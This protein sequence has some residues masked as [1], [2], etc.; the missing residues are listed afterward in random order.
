MKKIL[1][2]ISVVFWTFSITAP[3]GA[4]GLNM[5][6]GLWQITS[7]VSMPG[8]SMPPTSFKQCITKQDLVPRNSQPGQECSV[9]NVKQEG[10]RVSWT[11]RCATPG[12]S[13]EGNGEITYKG[14]TFSGDMLMKI[15]GQQGMEMK[16]HMEGRRIGNCP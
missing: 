12:G 3:A 7:T 10:D 5:Q 16:T 4:A 14:D 1:V 15:S 2:I 11:L 8:M 13:M 9:G 6:E